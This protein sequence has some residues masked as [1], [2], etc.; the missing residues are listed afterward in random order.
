M[1]TEI[2]NYP[3]LAE[4]LSREPRPLHGSADLIRLFRQ[5]RTHAMPV[6]ATRDSGVL[7]TLL[8]AFAGKAVVMVTTVA[9]RPHAF[10]RIDYGAGELV[11]IDAAGDEIGENEVRAEPAGRMFPD[12]LPV[13]LGCVDNA[14]LLEAAEVARN[15][16]YYRTLHT[17]MRAIQQ[18][19]AHFF[20]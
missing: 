6:L 20:A 5:L 19:P 8:A 18:G 16:G 12:A 4:L 7:A 1:W 11:D 9:D 14:V 15:C 3:S 2:D 13:Q 10:V 17:L